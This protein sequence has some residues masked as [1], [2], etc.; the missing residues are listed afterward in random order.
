[1]AGKY[2]GLVLVLV[3]LILLQVGVQL[4]A[5]AVWNV[6]DANGWTFGVQSWPN[7]PSFKPFRDGDMLVFKYDP[8]AHNV[9]VVDDFGFGTC[10]THP[11]NATVYSSGSDRITLQRGE[12]NFIS[13]KANDCE[14]GLKITVFVRP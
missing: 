5:A 12:T 6:G 3:S 2:G 1:M 13:G 9:I 7:N 14:K 10:T 11:A 4:A 8:A